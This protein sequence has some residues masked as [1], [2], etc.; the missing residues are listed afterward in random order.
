MLIRR[1]IVESDRP[2]IISTWLR[3]IGKVH[4][5]LQSLVVAGIE[6]KLEHEHISVVCEERTP[7][8]VLGWSSRDTRYV[9]HD[10]RGHHE[11]SDLLEERE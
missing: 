3:T 5:R 1:N 11:I 9:P 6:S 10:L 2:Y 7:H 4:K 8:V